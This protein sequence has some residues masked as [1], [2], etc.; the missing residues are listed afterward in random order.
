MSASD[1]QLNEFIEN[2]SLVSV[3]RDNIHSQSLQAFPIR[4]SPSLLLVQYVC[5]F[6]LDGQLIVRREDITSITCRATDKFQRT[7]LDDNGVIDKVDFAFNA[8]LSSFTRL[9]KSRPP[10]SIVILEEEGLDDSTFWIGRFVDA[11]NGTVRMH[12]FSGAANWRDNLTRIGQDDITC[13]QLNTNYIRFYAEY[14]EAHP[15]P[16]VPV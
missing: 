4:F 12:E 11:D 15:A 1:K 2:R 13:C 10:R 6:R 7:L 14:F 9:L 16:E 3:R 5:D 8:E